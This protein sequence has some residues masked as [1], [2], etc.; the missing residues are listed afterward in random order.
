MSLAEATE[1]IQHAITPGNCCDLYYPGKE[2]SELQ[3]FPTVVDNRFYFSLPALNEGATNTVIYNPNQGLSDVVLT[4]TLPAPSGALTY[5]GWAFP[6]NW[7][8]GMIATVALRVGGSS[9]YYFTGDQ[10]LVDTLTDC[11]DSGKK[12]AVM[13]LGGAE[14]LQVS[15]YASAQNLTA[16]VYLKLPFNSISSLQKTLPLP[17]DLLSQPV[18]ILVTFKR[19]SEVAYWYSG[20]SANYATL[21]NSFASASVNFRQTVLQNSEHL[22]ARRENMNEKALT[23][24]L[25]YF[26]QTSFRTNVRES[27]SNPQTINLTGFRSGSLKYIDVYARKVGYNQASGKCWDFKPFLSVQLLINGLVFYDTRNSN[28]VMWSLCDRKTPAQTNNTQLVSNAGNNARAVPSV[29]PWIPISFSQLSEPMA[30]HNDVTLGYNIANSVINLVVQL[31]DDDVY[32]VTANY[33]YACA[34]MAS[35]G[36]MEYVF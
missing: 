31:P 29:M 19:F 26:A 4:A 18:Q 28:N 17:T 34:L 1:S 14:L 25:R 6:R 23:V 9:L 15:D 33:H 13:A 30:F 12:D 20:G 21:C 3:C 22:L 11:E 36:T 24:P 10:I 32:E 27:F 2:N 5:A 7:L 16:S 35:K 8:G